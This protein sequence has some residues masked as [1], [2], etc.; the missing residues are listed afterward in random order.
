MACLVGRSVC[1]VVFS[2]VARA[3]RRPLLEDPSSMIG[4]T[5]K[6]LLRVAVATVATVADVALC[7][8]SFA[9]LIMESQAI[10]MIGAETSSATTFQIT[11]T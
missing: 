9:T 1:V 5:G 2:F 3:F 11:S 7:V 10:D 8:W 6:N 4:V